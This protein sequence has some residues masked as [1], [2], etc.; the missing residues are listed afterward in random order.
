MGTAASKWLS[1]PTSSSEMDGP[2]DNTRPPSDQVATM[3]GSAAANALRTCGG[4]PIRGRS[5]SRQ[6][7]PRWTV[8][9][10]NTAMA[11]MATNTA[12]SSQKIRPTGSEL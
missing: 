1:A 9:G 3:D 6:P 4:T 5:E 2:S 7:S 8:S 10:R 12:S 11:A